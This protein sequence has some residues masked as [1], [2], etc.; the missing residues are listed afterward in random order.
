M[1]RTPA[2]ETQVDRAVT[3]DGCWIFGEIDLVGSVTRWDVG[4]PDESHSREER[5]ASTTQRRA[6]ITKRNPS[7]SSGKDTI[8]VNAMSALPARYRPLLELMA[9]PDSI[10]A[11]S[12]IWV[13]TGGEE[14][15]ATNVTAVTRPSAIRFFI[16]S[17]RRSPLWPFGNG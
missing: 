13:E 1:L 6:E 17:P 16:G 8:L 2:E 3:R 5:T 15:P 14:Q 4:L 9:G 10:C 7:W 12:P 11:C